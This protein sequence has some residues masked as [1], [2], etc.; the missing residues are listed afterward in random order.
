MR[1]RDIL[2]PVASSVVAATILLQAMV[3]PVFV[4]S[5]RYSDC[6]IVYA[7]DS[8]DSGVDGDVGPLTDSDDAV[9]YQVSFASGGA[10]LSDTVT[11]VTSSRRQAEPLSTRDW[12][13]YSSDYFESEMTDSELEYYNRLES[14]AQYY[15]DTTADISYSSMSKGYAMNGIRYSD[16]GLTKSEAYNVA[17]W[18]VFNNLQ[19][20]FLQPSFITTNTAVYIGCYD[21]A[22]NGADRARI[23]AD[24]FSTIDDWIASVTDDELTTYQTVVSTHNLLCDEL[25]YQKNEYDQSL[26]SVTNVGSTVCA[27]YAGA[28]SVIANAVGIDTIV[29]LSSNHAWDYVQLD[30]GQYY[31]TDVTWD[32]KLGVDR[33]LN[34]GSK[35]ISWYDSSSREHTVEPDWLD[36]LPNA[37]YSDYTVTPYDLTGSFDPSTMTLGKPSNLHVDYT[38]V[39]AVWNPVTWATSYDIALYSSG[40]LLQSFTTSETKVDISSVLDYS[41]VT[42][43]VRSIVNS[44]GQTYYSDWASVSFSPVND[45]SPAVP[46]DFRVASV[47]DTSVGLSWFPVDKAETYPIE[48]YSDAG[49]TKLLASSS[50]PQTSLTLNNMAGRTI[51]ARVRAE[52]TVNGHKYQS[53]WSNLTVTG[54]TV[55]ENVDAPSNLKAV[56]SGSLTQVSWNSVANAVKYDIQICS[57]SRYSNV[58]AKSTLQGTTLNLNG[59]RSGS[60]YYIQVRAIKVVNGHTCYSDW[61]KL[62]YRPDN[63]DLSNSSSL[64]TPSGFKCY[65]TS[66]KLINLS[67]SQVADASQYEIQIGTDS[68]FKTVLV[69]SKLKSSSLNLSGLH[70]GVTYYVRVR[71][72]SGSAYSQWGTVSVAF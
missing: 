4:S 56:K 36:W 63:S 2:S 21:M 18:F 64:S 1:G 46:V 20:Y 30:D 58:L 27:G 33:L 65:K 43:Y 48:L 6:D 10:N 23:T 69:S 40:S 50:N 60:T 38:G 70:S 35:T 32:D 3:S 59:L 39:N 45:L 42:L 57:D 71:A 15:M 34:C 24:V 55:S 37:A 29:A 54:K 25:S 8:S 67:W 5:D 28:F 47:E 44:D 9:I 14:L 66:S 53:D 16:L 11:S 26:Y 72:I 13:I 62:P 12:S 22:A 7:V 68:S 17:Q 41:D 61:T 51:Y 52:R 49:Y 19:Y 31:Q